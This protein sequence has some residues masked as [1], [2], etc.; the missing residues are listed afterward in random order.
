MENIIANNGFDAA[1]AGIAIVFAGLVLIAVVIV[2]FNFIMKPSQNK[3]KT[4]KLVVPEQ[5][6]VKKENL[7]PVKE[8]HL[9][10]IATAI[11]LYRKLHFDVLQNEITF[12][13]GEDA[14]NAWKMGHKFGQREM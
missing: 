4:K 2:I 8:D 6:T 10:A 12:V 1:L 13:R 7:K 14:A 11:E 5:L 9:V 3:E